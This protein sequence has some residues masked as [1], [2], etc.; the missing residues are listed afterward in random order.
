[1]LRFVCS[2]FV[3][4]AL[5][6]LHVPVARAHSRASEFINF[7][8]LGDMRQAGSFYVQVKPGL[9]NSSVGSMQK[10]AALTR[11]SND[12]GCH[13]PAY[14][15]WLSTGLTWNGI[16]KPPAFSVTADGIG[17]SD[18]TNGQSPTAI[19]EPSSFYLLGAGLSAVAL[20]RMRRMF[21]A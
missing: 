19:P 5:L 20:V 17:A 16:S 9:G 1:M 8:Q 7:N 3:F 12:G 18:T 6:L 2:L 14:C 13:G 10:F 21:P 11:S 15:T 4:S